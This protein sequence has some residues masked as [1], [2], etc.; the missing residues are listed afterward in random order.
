MSATLSPAGRSITVDCYEFW[1]RVFRR[2][3]LLDYS[4]GAYYGDAALPYE[5]AQRNQVSML[6]NQV[7]FQPGS[8]VLDIGCGN[9]TLLSEVRR[10]GGIG[11][12]VTI[13]PAQVR[14]CRQQG[15]DAHLL[16][17][18]DI[19]RQWSRRFDAVIA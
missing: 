6:L 12:G 9:G 8:R 7:N 11:T 4:E 18:R 10:R 3:G 19:S 14:F 5:Q 17:Y 15:L 1:D 13:S 16:D 2:A